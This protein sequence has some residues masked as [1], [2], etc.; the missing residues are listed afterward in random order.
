[1]FC[2]GKSIAE[3]N[4]PPKQSAFGVERIVRM[5]SGAHGIISS[6]LSATVQRAALLLS[7]RSPLKL[8]AIYTDPLC[9]ARQRIQDVAPPSAGSSD[10][11]VFHSPVFMLQYA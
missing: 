1:M 8:P 11:G 7:G 10:S 9:T 2:T 6:V 4:C 3:V 5:F